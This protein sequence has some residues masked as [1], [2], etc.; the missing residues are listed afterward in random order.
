MLRTA[1]LGVVMGN[2]DPE[3]RRLGFGTTGGNDACGVAEALDRLV[4]PR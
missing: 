4:P 2:A 1:G 3:L